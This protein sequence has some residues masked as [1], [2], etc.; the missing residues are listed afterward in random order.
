MTKTTTK[1]KDPTRDLL[2]ALP[3]AMFLGNPAGTVAIWQS[4]IVEAGG[5]PDE[6][7]AW[8]REHGGQ[9]DRSFPPSPR[10]GLRVGRQAEP[11]HFYV[12]PESALS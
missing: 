1:T 10:K 3:P 6:V 9:L 11:K 2:A 12:I 7:L 5:D 4:K 8:V